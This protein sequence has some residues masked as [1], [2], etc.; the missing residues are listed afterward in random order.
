M[1]QIGCEENDIHTIIH[2]F[3]PATPL[4][5]KGQRDHIHPNSNMIILLSLSIHPK[6]RTSRP[7]CHI[8]FNMVFFCCDGC[9][10]TLKKSQV[11]AHAY[12]CRQCESVSC[13]DCNVSFWGGKTAVPC[14]FQRKE[15]ECSEDH[16]SI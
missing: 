6:E 12:K 11:D 5:A 9:G 16:E 15:M 4:K 3:G 8:L 7:L 1:F 2:L 10:A 14:H 13:V